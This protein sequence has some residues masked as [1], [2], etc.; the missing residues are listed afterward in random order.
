[1]KKTPVSFI[2]LGCRIA[3]T[4]GMVLCSVLPTLQADDFPSDLLP[5][6]TGTL[7]ATQ[8]ITFDGQPVQIR[9]FSL[10]LPS[11][12][13]AP[14]AAGSSATVS[15]TAT[16]RAR[17]SNN[18][19]ASF[20]SVSS[21]ADVTL[22]LTSSSDGSTCDAEILSLFV[23]GGE[24]PPSVRLRESPTKQSTGRFSIVRCADGTCRISSFFDIFT[25]LSLNSGQSWTPSSSAAR[26]VCRAPSSEAAFSS[27]H[28]PP[29]T[30]AY[31][32]PWRGTFSN[33]AMLRDLTISDPL[34]S[35]DPPASGAPPVDVTTQV[36]CT[37][38]VSLDG[39][40]SFQPFACPASL[41]VHVSNQL[42][43]TV[44]R[45]F[46]TEMLALSLSGGSLPAG[47]MVRESPTKASTGRTSVRLCPDG[48]CR[49][50]SFFDIFTEISLDGGVIWSPSSNGACPSAFG[51]D[52]FFST[53][54]FPVAADYACAAGDFTSFG[55]SGV[56][57]RDQKIRL[58]PGTRGALAAQ[59]VDETRAMPAQMT[60]D[61]SVDGGVTFSRVVVDCFT[62]TS[63]TDLSST[64]GAKSLEMLALSCTIPGAGSGTP[65][66]SPAGIMVR[67]SPTL[68]ST[69][70]TRVCTCPDG[71]MVSSFFDIFTEISLDGG[72]SW[73]PA[74]SPMHASLLPYVEQDNVFGSA[75]AL[76]RDG[77]L[78][79][80]PNDP[81]I[82]FNTLSRPFMSKLRTLLIS[83][84]S[85]SSPL[86]EPKD[87][88]ENPLYASCSCDV[89]NDGGQTWTTVTGTAVGSVSVS[90]VTHEDSWEAPSFFDTE[91][92]S[93]SALLSSGG[94]T[95]FTVM[96]RES[97]TLKSTGQTTVKRVGDGSACRMESFFD[98]FT[99]LSFDGGATWSPAAS[100]AHLELHGTPEECFTRSPQLPLA[101][102]LSSPDP[103]FRISKPDGHVTVLKI[104]FDFSGPSAGIPFHV[105]P[106]APGSSVVCDSTVPVS[107]DYCP[108]GSTAF[109]RVECDAAISCSYTGLEDGSFR[110]EML[111]C[112]LSGGSLPP[113][114]RLR[115]SPS[116]P[117]HGRTTL[118]SCP[119]GECVSSFF[120]I[121]V[122]LST[123]GGTTF[124]PASSPVRVES[125]MTSNR[126]ASAPSV[127]EIV[128]TR[129][130]SQPIELSPRL[131]IGGAV[132]R[133]ASSA[134]V[135]LPAA[136]SSSVR[137]DT[138]T[139]DF[140]YCPDATSPPSRLHGDVFLRYEMKE[141]V[142]SSYCTSFDTEMLQLECSGLPSGMRLRESPTLP[143]RGRTCIYPQPDG[144]CRISSF[145]DV[146]T[147]LSLDGGRTWSALDLPLH[148]SF[149]DAV[150]SSNSPDNSW[151]PPGQF[152]RPA[153]D[154]ASATTFSNGRVMSFF[155]IFTELSAGRPPLPSV[156]SPPLETTSSG[157]CRLHLAGTG[158]PVDQDCDVQFTTR[159][160]A[161]GIFSDGTIG[162]DTEM[163]ALSLSSSSGLPP[164]ALVRESPTRQSIGHTR[165]RSLSS[166]GAGGGSGGCAVDSFFDVF[167]ELSL[168]GGATWSACD[169][170]MRLAFVSPEIEVS[171]PAGA[172]ITDGGTVT[173]NASITSTLSIEVA[174]FVVHNSG[175]GPLTGLGFSFEGPDAS[176]FS[177]PNPPVGPLPPG[178]TT[179]FKVA[180]ASNSPG[181][182]TATLHITS[183]DADEASFDIVLSARAFAPDEDSDDD[184]LSD[185]EELALAGSGFDPLVNSSV[186]TDFLRDNGFFRSSDMH[187]LALGR[188]VLERNA[189]TGHFHLRLGIRESPTLQSWSA[190]TNFSPTFDAPSG[191]IDLDIPPSGSNTRFYQVLGQEP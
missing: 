72:G 143:S 51:R 115:E 63:L 170:P 183:N 101:V 45:Y 191:I 81:P 55:T 164:G 172:A 92:T 113:E 95:P 156:G 49:I 85:V 136:G 161:T 14:P 163:L 25:E 157:R 138:G 40:V 96:L 66:G 47:V 75:Y 31:R 189:D 84:N 82:P 28:L 5:P 97:P 117:S 182:R 124:D 57:M 112:A 38:T 70:R 53:D 27:A 160:T 24:L 35:V 165:C 42:D 34:T 39:G 74:G 155:D 13:I 110:C 150:P 11:T 119:S 33:G 100:A 67:E 48:S 146:F 83:S 36:A 58:L 59:G 69:G 73:L 93:F 126:E 54:A 177:V 105:S 127:S 87:H 94:T 137:I 89:S 158:E 178:G 86:Y 91:M 140:L 148:Y 79:V 185:K 99:E 7:D 144:S 46:D 135:T 166:G 109:T 154:L 118:R 71:Y 102:C 21:S 62:T 186:E 76:P 152:Q 176:S 153:S 139:M 68:A 145:F 19:G 22:H 175:S 37:G 50:G 26:C 168:D 133:C 65:A 121:F 98:V 142:V 151:P 44:T 9:D 1:M 78:E 61:V 184:G 41:T 188:P 15:F 134:P 107:F 181:A 64:S 108:E 162:Y 30:C 60:C 179:A 17:M 103:E 6:P 125:C 128:V 169:A 129:L 29:P 106:P 116:R 88:S 52:H 149:E 32:N 190:L 104:A 10:R 131:R 56:V 159:L 90:R 18:N 111:S 12:S 3:F 120:D 141:V 173:V 130:V 23:F 171:P 187:G 16:M 180:F 2:R 43:G 147:E 167:T 80:R 122:E 114:F 77:S 174:G 4:T 20:Q 123:D 132:L 8:I